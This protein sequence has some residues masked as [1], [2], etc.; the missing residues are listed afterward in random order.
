MRL[1]TRAHVPG[2]LALAFHLMVSPLA[3][4]QATR[5][6]LLAVAKGDSVLL[7]L[8]ES[9]P[10]GGGFVVYRARVGVTPAPRAPERITE[11]PVRPPSDPGEVAATFGAELDDILAAT[12]TSDAFAA[13]RW[14]A[15][16]PFAAAVYPLLFRSAGPALG[17]FFGDGGL[18]RGATYEY[19]V[20][21]TDA[22]GAET[23]RALSA[24]VQLTDVVPPLPTALEARAG[25]GEV[26]LRWKY[27]AYS[28]S[29]T[30]VAIGF[31][32]YRAPASG[33]AARRLTTR[34]IVRLEGTPLEFRDATA[35]NGVRYRYSV[36]V[37]DIAGRETAAGAELIAQA[38]DR[39]PPGTPTDAIAKSG[40]GHVLLVWRMSPE[41]DAAG[42]HVDR[43]L[44]IGK[45]YA[46]LTPTL[47]PADQPRWLD[48]TARG[49]TQYFY[50][51]IAVD[52][53]GNASRP[54]NGL[55]A[56]PVDETPPLP[57]SNITARVVDRRLVLRWTGS[58]S[59]D[60]KGYYIYRGDGRDRLVRLVRQPVSATQ[61]VDSGFAGAGLVPGHRYALSV[62]AVDHSYNE[63]PQVPLDVAV[64][65]DEPPTPPTS[66]AA[67]NVL[68]RH[69]ELTWVASAALDVKAYELTRRGLAPDT[70]TVRLGAFDAR[71]ATTTRDTAVAHGKQYIYR[72]VAVDSAGNR[73]APAVD[74]VSFR[75]PTPPPASR[76]LDAV[77]TPAG[78]VLTWERVVSNELVGYHV[79][80]GALPTSVG[81]RITSAPVQALTFTD[82]AGS[83]TAYYVV[84]A[85]DRSGNE[86]AAS[87]A[88]RAV[89]P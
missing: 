88:A 62:S 11:V 22:A 51:V 58:P 71:G 17:R 52:S 7:F 26:T 60:V 68:G 15:A 10:A 30:D 4:Q 1:M 57:P 41:P 67:R 31:H 89:R 2:A 85:V 73:S 24:R 59:T 84:R 54:T 75:S 33:G 46:R 35:A 32:V 70:A 25:D 55:S 44:G 65:D 3:A 36:R 80:R 63:S 66:F 20:V 82:R 28:G 47:L 27:R 8:S 48:T 23:A 14:I 9:P 49:G 83:A 6:P 18:T 74:T 19:R 42:Y 72:L 39:T 34:P 78:V 13:R 50:R 86:S 16:D 37:V 87:P 12:R 21:F 5:P 76:R 79:Y 29:P 69:V 45:P 81:E 43:S 64:P 56:L 38:V 53:A 77:L 61:F 40:D